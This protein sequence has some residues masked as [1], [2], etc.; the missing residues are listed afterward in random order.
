MSAHESALAALVHPDVINANRARLLSLCTTN[1][2]AQVS[3]TIA[4]IEAEYEQMWAEDAD[5]HVCLC[6]G[7]SQGLSA[8]AVRASSILTI[9][10]PL[11]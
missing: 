2:L 11:D 4:Q 5:G 9:D 7:L 10:P 8:Y 3:P 6:P 1:C